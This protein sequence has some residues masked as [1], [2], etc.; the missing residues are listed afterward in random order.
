MTESEILEKYQQP[1]PVSFKV[2]GVGTGATDIIE[3]VKSF[4]Y[5]CVGCFIA[6]SPSDCTHND[7]DKMVIIVAQDNEDVA[8]AIAKMY[9]DAGIL[10]IGLVHDPDVSCYDNIA[11]DTNVENVPDIINHLLL[12]I[13]SH[14]YVCYDFN[15][16]CV[17]L[18]SSES[19]R[20]MTAEGE[21]VAKAVNNMKKELAK[22]PVQ[23][24]EALSMHL[25]FNYER[26]P[27]VTMADMAHLSEMISGLP[28]SISVVLSVNS[29]DTL[30]NDLIRF[31]V[32]MSG[33][34]L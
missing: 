15:D 7:N 18:R 34:E 17:T 31:S 6:E 24:I 26:R 19:F 23:R 1:H 11:A 33:N 14:G 27:A 3:K 12:P 20:T 16:F 9:H 30:P 5:D 10:T 22:V 4:G 28:A 21:N 13:V 29:D 2:I 8:N 32:I 25:F